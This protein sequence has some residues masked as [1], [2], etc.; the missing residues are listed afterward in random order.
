MMTDRLLRECRSAL[1]S[2]SSSHPNVSCYLLY[3]LPYTG[4]ELSIFRSFLL[5]HLE[6]FPQS[7]F[8][9]GP[10]PSFPKFPP[11]SSALVNSAITLDSLQSWPPVNSSSPQA[12]SHF[13]LLVPPLCNFHSLENLTTCCF[14][15][16]S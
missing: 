1:G 14:S 12:L 7:S 10:F 15:S 8:V 2:L 4:S 6:F 3:L 9:F 13:Y 5:V 16:T 11:L